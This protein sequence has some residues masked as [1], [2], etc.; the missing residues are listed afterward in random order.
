MGINPYSKNEPLQ[1]VIEKKAINS[2]MFREVRRL[3]TE[4]GNHDGAYVTGKYYWQNIIDKKA[5]NRGMFSEA[6][7]LK[8]GNGNRDGAYVTGK[9]YCLLK[10]GVLSHKKGSTAELSF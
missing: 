6:R 3:K 1:N 7:R 9:Y 10:L 2:G 5:I 8:T 4:N